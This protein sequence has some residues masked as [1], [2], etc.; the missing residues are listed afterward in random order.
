M[1]N[2]WKV[3]TSFRQAFAFGTSRT[4]PNTLLTQKLMTPDE[5][6]LCAARGRH[7]ADRSKPVKT[8]E[9]MVDLVEFLFES[10][11]NVADTRCESLQ[12]CLQ[13][14]LK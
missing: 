14:F 8:H 7:T 11:L 9:R 6:V 3:S 1:S 5:V 2:C 10:D 4:V 12:S 13:R